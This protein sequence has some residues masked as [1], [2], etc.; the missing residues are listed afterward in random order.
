V[1]IDFQL[2]Y[3][4]SQEQPDKMLAAL[5]DLPR[6]INTIYSLLLDRIQGY[7][8]E[9][10][11]VVLR[12]FSWLFYSKGALTLE[13]VREAIVIEDGDQNL[14]E[15]RLP[16]GDLIQM[17]QGLVKCGK[18]SRAV[19]FTHITVHEFFSCRIQCL[20]APVQLGKSCLVYLNFKEFETG[21][22]R[23]HDSLK[24]R[25]ANYRF[26]RYAA[27]CWADLIRGEGEGHLDVAKAAISVLSCP[28]KRAA[29]LQ[30]DAS[31]FLAL[32]LS[33][34]NSQTLLHVLARNGLS[35]FCKIVLNDDGMDPC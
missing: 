34:F 7:R 29:M 30:L 20:P 19:F 33:Y 31:R 4:L 22:C 24:L 1:L 27:R 12:L 25:L 11:K 16:H 15:D 2:Q 13:E 32:H 35:R 14:R 17:C 9:D 10:K 28:K 6:D 23:D 18:K 8:E 26:S 3:I 21:T 5:E